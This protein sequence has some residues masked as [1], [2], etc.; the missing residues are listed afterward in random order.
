MTDGFGDNEAALACQELTYFVR[1]SDGSVHDEEKEPRQGE[2]DDAA[3]LTIT[4]TVGS[5]QLTQASRLAAQAIAG[6]TTD[7]YGKVVD[8]GCGGGVLALLAAAQPRVDCVVGLDYEAQNIA[9]RRMNA[10]QNGLSHKAKFYRSDSFQCLEDSLQLRK[11]LQEKVDFII[12]N[13]PASKDDDGFSFR[14][15]ILRE[16]TQFLK[17]HGQVIIQA[18]SYYGSQ[19]FVKGAEQATDWYNNELKQ[20]GNDAPTM[21]YRYLGVVKASP[22]LELGSGPGGY[23]FKPQLEQYCREER[24]PGGLRYFC[25]PRTLDDNDS[26]TISVGDQQTALQAMATWKKTQ[27]PPLC[28]W[29][30]HALQWEPLKMQS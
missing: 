16:A 25:G 17:P 15:R 29:H 26:A 20:G 5:F 12:A 24:R 7:L 19:R 18:L 23:D 9:T 8:W 28:Q 10:K 3:Y 21:H 22:W 11:L 1:I 6:S 4:A 2:T 30:M 13:P 14:R 27:K